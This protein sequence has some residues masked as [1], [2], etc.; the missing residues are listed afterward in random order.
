[1]IS[2]QSSYRRRFRYEREV[3]ELGNC[4][5]YLDVHQINV[6]FIAAE[7]GSTHH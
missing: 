7:K 1:M 2:K 4:Q 3:A 6:G 5:A